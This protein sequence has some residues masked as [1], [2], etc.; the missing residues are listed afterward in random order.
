MIYELRFMIGRK[1]ARRAVANHQSSFLSPQFRRACR[2]GAEWRRAFTL[3]EML[4]VLAILGIIAA[5]TVPALKNFGRLDAMTA[6][7]QQMLSA[8]A[9]ARQLAMSQRTTV[10][11][12]FVPMNFWD[13]MDAAQRALPATTNLCNEQL[14]GYTFMSHGKMG[15]QPGQHQWTYL[16][17]WQTLPAGT[18]IATNKFILPLQ[19]FAIPAYNPNVAIYG[20]ALT[21]GIPF[22]TET[23]NP[24]ANPNLFLPYLAFNYLGQLVSDV[25]AFGHYRKAIIPL[26][27]GSV[28]PAVHP[29]S[30]TFELG[31]PQV[32]ED[33]PGN[34]TNAYNII[35][36]DPLTGRATLETPKVK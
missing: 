27:R 4:V 1:A 18:F 34:S 14:T 23:N 19:S 28:A 31:S 8:V 10:Y 35:N 5:L 13:N 16:D 20:F 15:D 11:M 6:A 24:A 29:E 2:A 21:N 22:P 30:R 33:P 26:A 3:I 32:T 36:I 17:K 9:R 7:D 12:V 25:D